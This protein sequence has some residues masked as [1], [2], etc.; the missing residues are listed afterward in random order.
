MYVPRLP[1]AVALGGNGSSNKL[2]GEALLKKGYDVSIVSFRNDQ[3]DLDL[4]Y[5][6]RLNVMTMNEVDIWGTYHFVFFFWIDVPKYAVYSW[7]V[8]VLF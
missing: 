2:V 3:N 5:D 4:K 6:K 8:I 7:S 1:L